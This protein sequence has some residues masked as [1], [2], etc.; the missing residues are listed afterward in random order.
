MKGA[1]ASP[2]LDPLL[3]LQAPMSL[4]RIRNAEN[5]YEVQSPSL[6]VYVRL[7]VKPCGAHQFARLCRANVLCILAYVRCSVHTGQV[8][9]SVPNSV[10]SYGAQNVSWC[11]VLS[12]NTTLRHHL[13]NVKSIGRTSTATIHSMLQRSSDVPW[14][15]R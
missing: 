7:C 8:Y 5:P 15:L 1:S 3:E 9:S 2:L 4:L 13:C 11:S 12:V 14:L 6:A 10:E